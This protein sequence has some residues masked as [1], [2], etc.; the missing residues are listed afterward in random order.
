VSAIPDPSAWPEALD[1]LAAAPGFHRLLLENDDVRVLETV[2]GP[3][4][5]TPVHTHCW[6]SVLYVLSMG[7]FVRR[8]GA[9][10]VLTDTRAAGGYPD[11]GSAA[12]SEAMPPH[13]F[14]NVG[15]TEVRVVNVELKR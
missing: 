12:W 11:P 14:E 1:A 8:D 15:D 10:N 4:E 7:H 5:R 9:G 2:I 6:P 13:T 3:G